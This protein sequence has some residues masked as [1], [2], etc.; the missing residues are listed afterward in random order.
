MPSFREAEPDNLERVAGQPGEGS[1]LQLLAIPP[2]GSA[3]PQTGDSLTTRQSVP[4]VVKIPELVLHDKRTN[5][6]RDFPADSPIAVTYKANRDSVVRINTVNAETRGTEGSVGT[7]FFVNKDG[8]IATG[9]H[10]IKDA[11]AESISVH[12][13]NGKTYKAR[14][15]RVDPSKDL[16]LLQVEKQTPGEQFKPSELA[17]SSDSVKPGSSM[18]ALGYPHNVEAMHVSAIKAKSREVLAKLRVNGGILTG[19]DAQRVVVRSE[20]NVAKG[21]SGGPVLDPMTGKVV[22]VVNLSNEVDTYFNPVE[23]LKQFLSKTA[24]QIRPLLSFPGLTASRPGELPAATGGRIEISAGTLSGVTGKLPSAKDFWSAPKLSDGGV[25]TVLPAMS[26]P[27]YKPPVSLQPEAAKSASPSIS[28][29]I[30][31]LGRR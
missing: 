19:E 1:A 16:A 14:I 15:Y 6:T 22:G 31:E 5:I 21:N 20:G 17:D 25:P 26:N 18:I 7:G 30:Q 9:F 29:R 11:E 28:T 24:E 13:E 8:L 27:F 12:M 4:S 3:R 10:V 2:F 23:D